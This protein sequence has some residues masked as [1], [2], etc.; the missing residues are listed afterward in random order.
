MLRHDR[1]EQDDDFGA[2]LL[3]LLE[4]IGCA[5]VEAIFSNII[6]NGRR[7]FEQRQ[8]RHV[9]EGHFQ[10]FFYHVLQHLPAARLE[11]RQILVL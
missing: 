8:Q 9:F 3:Q 6:A 11:N 4:Q 7:A 1:A 10:D 2:Q 5:R